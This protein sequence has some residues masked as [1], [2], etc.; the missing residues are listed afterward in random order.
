VTDP[1]T[2]ATRERLAKFGR[3][4]FVNGI[5]NLV[6]AAIIYLTAV[7]AG[8]L[9]PPRRILIIAMLV[10]LAVSAYC[11]AVTLWPRHKVSPKVDRVATRVGHV[12]NVVGLLLMLTFLVLVILDRHGRPIDLSWITW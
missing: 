2:N 1:H 5:A 10:L 7:A 3:D 8:Y 11:L 12:L 9:E 4:V 6:A